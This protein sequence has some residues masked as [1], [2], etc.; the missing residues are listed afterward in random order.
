MFI[1]KD[2]T[3]G[4]Y[5][6]GAAAREANT[7]QIR[8]NTHA[9]S[10]FAAALSTSIIAVIFALFPVN[11]ATANPLASFMAT[12]ADNVG[13]AAMAAFSLSTTVC[14]IMLLALVCSSRNCRRRHHRLDCQLRID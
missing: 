1:N 5:G 3:D 10:L 12:S 9:L 8:R 4:L 11:T 13:V 7:A 6:F 2:H 14:A